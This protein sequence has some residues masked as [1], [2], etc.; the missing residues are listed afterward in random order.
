M[1]D[2]RQLARQYL[3]RLGYKDEDI[4]YRQNKGG[5]G[6]DIY[7][8]GQY[9]G[10]GTP[11]KDGYTR[12]NTTDLD[13]MHT[14][15]KGNQA[16]TQSSEL[17]KQYQSSLAQPVQPFTYDENQIR[18]SAEFKAGMSGLLQD[19]QSATNRGLVN[20]GRRGI[21]N[22]QSA[23]T[24]TTANQ[25]NAVNQANNV[26]LPRLIAENYQKFVDQQ[27]ATRQRN[28]DMLGLAGVYRDQ[29]IDQR[30]FDYQTGRDKVADNRYN[31]EFEYQK[32]RDAIADERYKLEFDEDVRRYGLDYAL[33][34]AETNNQMANRNAQTAMD[35]E[36]LELSKREM[37]LREKEASK[38][39]EE[40]NRQLFQE[41]S[42]AL[43]DVLRNGEMTP[44]EAIKQIE[45]DLSFGFYTKEQA[46]QLKQ[47]VTSLTPSI[48]VQPRQLTDAELST[49]PSDGELDKLYEQEAKPKGYAKLDWKQWFR[50]PNGRLGGVDFP[51]WHTLYG[52]KLTAR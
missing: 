24:M 18:N 30:N 4:T 45:E 50:D 21:G 26:L 35:R 36:R 12:F 27:N 7:V 9:F 52:P 43:T 16:A 46:D 20:L 6:G 25:Q 31:Q 44:T 38:R 40:E 10:T 49:I 51:T 39:T 15:F 34:K 11:D 37:D 22:S 33:R 23:V 17:L 42:R 2:T 47:I 41:E 19:A 1:A 5:Q 8:Q 3:N 14:R 48:P 29:A 13:S 32:A 28:Q